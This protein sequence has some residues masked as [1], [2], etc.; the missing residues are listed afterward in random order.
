MLVVQDIH[1]VSKPRS[2]KYLDLKKLHFEGGT[3]GAFSLILFYGITARPMSNLK[4]QKSA[5]SQ[6]DTSKKSNN[7]QKWVN[8]IDGS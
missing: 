4:H 8:L 2:E 3:P 5:L 7:C 6:L 1:T